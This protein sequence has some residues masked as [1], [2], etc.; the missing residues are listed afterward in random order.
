MNGEIAN[1]SDE[2]M[3]WL[4]EPAPPYSPIMRVYNFYH[5]PEVNYTLHENDL[6]RVRYCAM[7]KVFLEITPIAS[8]SNDPFIIQGEHALKFLSSTNEAESIRAA[9]RYNI[10]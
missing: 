10:I 9:V 3:N 2:S 6:V 4:D 7:G 8:T 1:L 5:A